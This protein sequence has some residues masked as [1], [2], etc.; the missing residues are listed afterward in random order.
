MAVREEC[1]GRLMAHDPLT[2]RHPSLVNV[3]SFLLDHDGTAVGTAFADFAE[4]LLRAVP[5]DNAEFSVAMR[6]LIEARDAIGRCTQ[7]TNRPAGAKQRTEPT[8]VTPRQVTPLI[9][10]SRRGLRDDAARLAGD[11]VNEGWTVVVRQ[12]LQSL[13]VERVDEVPDDSVPAFLRMLQRG[14]ASMTQSRF[15]GGPPEVVL[16]P[17]TEQYRGGVEM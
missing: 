10:Q 3:A 5:A 7:P 15:S 17:A 6:K 1:V 2:G 13:G 12:A 16:P 14:K 4:T 11:L 8:V 9:G